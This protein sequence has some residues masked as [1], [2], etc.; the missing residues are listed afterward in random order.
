MNK[1][2]SL[3]SKINTMAVSRKIFNTEINLFRTIASQFSFNLKINGKQVILSQDNQAKLKE[4][5]KLLE[6]AANILL[7]IK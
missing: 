4:A 1:V 6:Q 2:L 5:T 7:E 3:K